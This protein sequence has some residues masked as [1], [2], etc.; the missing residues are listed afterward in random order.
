MFKMRS[1]KREGGGYDLS[2]GKGSKKLTA[3]LQEH[4]GKWYVTEGFGSG[5]ISAGKKGETQEAWGKMAEASYG[6]AP[7]GVEGGDECPGQLLIS[8]PPPQL[9]PRMGPPK[10]VKPFDGPTCPECKR[11]IT[12]WHN[13]LPPC[14][15]N[16]PNGED[17]IADPFDP[18]MS[19]DAGLTPVGALDQVFHW[20]LRNPTYV[21]TDGKLDPV[22]EGVRESL[23]RETKYPEYRP[24]R[25][26]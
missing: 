22:W 10:L 2:F 7:T 1:H 11:P 23:F 15:C 18:K 16:A 4:D 20:M 25:I 5:V 3:V 17:Y 19:T 26:T 9:R 14:R 13:G 6:S 24:G 12:G 21:I 8:K